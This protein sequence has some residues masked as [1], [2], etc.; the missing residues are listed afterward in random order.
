MFN[1]IQFL[2]NLKVSTLVSKIYIYFKFILTFLCNFFEIKTMPI[3]LI[4]RWQHKSFV[5]FIILN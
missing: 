5:I 3:F 1:F 4:N 2:L